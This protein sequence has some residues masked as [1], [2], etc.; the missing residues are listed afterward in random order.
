MSSPSSSSSGSSH[1]SPSPPP[2]SFASSLLPLQFTQSYAGE[3]L[4]ING[5]PL[6]TM[7]EPIYTPSSSP[8]PLSGHAANARPLFLSQ[9]HRNSAAE[10][11]APSPT[12][13]ELVGNKPKQ[14]SSSSIL[15]ANAKP[16]HAILATMASQTLLAKMRDA[17]W[18]AFAGSS[19][20]AETKKK[21]W[22]ADKVRR[23][24]DGTAVVRVV[25]V[26]PE[27]KTVEDPAAALEESMR[28][29]TL[30][31]NSLATVQMQTGGKKDVAATN[32]GVDALTGVF[33]GLRLA[34][35]GTAR[36]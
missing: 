10:R 32:A 25:D 11:A 4:G 27:Q 8:S 36:S 34:R 19:T 17:F 18:D 5:Q 23:V 15:A 29:L 14:A 1:S 22:D 6:Q 16:E 30:Q 35:T 7:P 9:M 2:M 20:T 26:E 13:S 3:Q 24:L 31:R 33:S 12:L 21:D 28:A